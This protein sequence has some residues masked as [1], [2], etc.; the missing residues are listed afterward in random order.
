MRRIPQP[1]K[2]VGGI[3]NNIV[4]KRCSVGMELGPAPSAGSGVC[5]ARPWW[6]AVATR[7]YVPDLGHGDRL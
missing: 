7:P 6:A 1:T 5:A 4:R 2:T 3:G